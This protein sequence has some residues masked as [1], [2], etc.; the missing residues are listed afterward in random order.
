M[1]S[2]KY[3]GE[4]NALASILFEKKIKIL[5]EKSATVYHE[6]RSLK[7]AILWWRIRAKSMK[8]AAIMNFY[9]ESILH[10]KIRF[11]KN[12]LTINRYIFGKVFV[13]IVMS[14]TLFIGKI[15]E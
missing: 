5:F 11:I 2:A 7:K 12:L 3:G 1:E 14:I 4:D 6:S 10:K 15:S 8:Q 9:E 13:V